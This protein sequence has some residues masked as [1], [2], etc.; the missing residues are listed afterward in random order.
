VRGRQNIYEMLGNRACERETE[1][2]QGVR[3]QSLGLGERNR[4][5]TR[6]EG[7]EPVGGGGGLAEGEVQAAC[8]Q[9]L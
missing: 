1:Q 5:Y 4:T 9:I 8:D 6:C 7:T 2:I 3:E